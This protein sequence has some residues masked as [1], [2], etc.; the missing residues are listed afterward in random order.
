MQGADADAQQVLQL[1]QPAAASMGPEGIVHTAGMRLMLH[2]A[3]AT[4]GPESTTGSSS[5]S[6]GSSSSGISDDAAAVCSADADAIHACIP[7][8]SS[9]VSSST[10][11]NAASA[12]SAAMAAY[13]LGAWRMKHGD[14]TAAQAAFQHAIAVSTSAEEPPSKSSSSGSSSSGG[15]R[16][17]DAGQAVADVKVH[18]ASPLDVARVQQ[19]E[20][21]VCTNSLVI[22]CMQ[23][24]AI[25]GMHAVHAR[26][27]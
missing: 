25:D 14:T 12:A 27:L 13:S 26:L 2:A 11:C 7:T 3:T 6:S 10:T 8:S 17:S 19:L 5:I 4:A 9:H 18:A 21:S 1:L 15:G 20:V 16:G 22:I 23:C 24:M